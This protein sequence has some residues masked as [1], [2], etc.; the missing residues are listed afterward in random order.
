MSPSW[1]IW[2]FSLAVTSKNKITLITFFDSNWK[3]CK[4]TTYPVNKRHRLWLKWISLYR[5]FRRYDV[6]IGEHFSIF[7]RHLH[8][9]LICGRWNNCLKLFERG[10]YLHRPLFFCFLALV[11]RSFF[12]NCSGLFDGCC[13]FPESKV[14]NTIWIWQ[15]D[16]IFYYGISNFDMMQ[17]DNTKRSKIFQNVLFRKR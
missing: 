3:F 16:W 15:F 14:M 4:W 5:I 12:I 11:R 9:P 10:K 2:I 7:D 8:M 1:I 13:S 6:E 17:H